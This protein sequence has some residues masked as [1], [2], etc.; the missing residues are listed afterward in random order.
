MKK[1]FT[2]FFICAL[3]ISLEA[4]DGGIEFAQLDWQATLAQAKKQDK[5]IFVDAYTTWCGPCKWMAKN[6]FPEQEVGN[7]YNENF[8]NAKIDMEKGEGILFA[9]AY[10]VRAFPTFLFIDAKGNLVHQ[11]LGSREVAEFVALGEAAQDPDQQVGTLK[12]KFEEGNREPEFLKNY[13]TALNNSGLKGAEEVASLY[14]E[15][16]K[17]WLTAENISF[18]FEQSPYDMNADLYKFIKDN[19]AAFSQE[20]GQEEVDN[21]LKYGIQSSL[22]KNKDITPA[23]IES[24][25]MEVFGEKGKEYSDAF[26]LQQLMFSRDRND[27]EKFFQ[28]AIAYADQYEIE[29]WSMLNSMAWRFFELTDD[30]NL[31]KHAKTWAKKSVHLNSNYANNDTL[32]WIHFKLKDKEK[33]MKYAQQA[34]ELAKADG[35]DYAETEKLV[36]QINM[37]E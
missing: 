29:S 3:V 7:F 1:L 8:V 28:A 33:A 9:K 30:P 31:L 26:Q 14:L 16:Q 36:E 21:K 27:E 15:S 6:V 19:R 17:D 12:A 34:I 25:F 20:I 23:E 37:L 4:Q 35:S 18:I 10:D 22:R 24:V 11:S 32:A 13:A 5:L 2:L